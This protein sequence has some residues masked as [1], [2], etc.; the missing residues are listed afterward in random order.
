VD[1]YDGPEPR[2]NIM[3]IR[4]VILLAITLAPPTWADGALPLF[5]LP[6]HPDVTAGGSAGAALAMGAGA[7]LL[8]PAGMAAG[9]RAELSLSIGLL[10]EDIQRHTGAVT[11]ALPIPLIPPGTIWGGCAISSVSYGS[12]E[13]RTI[14][15][16]LPEGEYGAGDTRADIAVAL[17]PLRGLHVGVSA[18][19]SEARI[20]D[21]SASAVSMGAGAIYS[22]R[23]PALDLGISGINMA[24]VTT[25]DA[26]GDLARVVQ[27][28]ARWTAVGGRLALAGGLRVMDDDDPEILAGTEY[29]VVQHLSLRAGRVFGHDTAGY[30]AGLGA[31]V[32]DLH[33]AYAF[34]EHGLDLGSSHRV[35]LTWRL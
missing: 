26:L 13:R 20:A 14:P 23:A 29:A 4:V 15:S 9:G 21:V 24:T 32:G 8:N 12:M 22:F 5:A 28:T 25:D 2:R 17:S 34:E 33:V 19:W 16:T 3:H 35:G 18:G 11:V 30:T 10:Y 1:G 31:T 27:A 7:V 6:D